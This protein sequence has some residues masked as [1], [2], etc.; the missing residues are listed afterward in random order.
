MKEVTP[1]VVAK[2]DE[3]AATVIQNA[4][5]EAASKGQTLDPLRAYYLH[6]AAWASVT[7]ADAVRVTN[8][9]SS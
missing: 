8:T 4:T 7:G 9:S 3:H 5:D 2:A 1:S 6:K